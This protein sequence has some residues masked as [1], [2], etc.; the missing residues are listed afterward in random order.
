MKESCGASNSLRVTLFFF[1]YKHKLTTLFYNQSQRKVKQNFE[2]IIWSECDLKWCRRVFKFLSSWRKLG[3]TS[4][5][6]VSCKQL[7]L[8]L[9]QSCFPLSLA[10]CFCLYVV[11]LDWNFFVNK[12]VNALSYMYIRMQYYVTTIGLSCIN[13]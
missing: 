9:K 6:T 12:T 4:L 2:R 1:N 3:R 7:K 11:L 8:R 5:P 10:F 13:V